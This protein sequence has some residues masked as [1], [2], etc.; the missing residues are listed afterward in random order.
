M[1]TGRRVEKLESALPQADPETAPAVAWLHPVDCRAALRFS[2]DAARAVLDR[3]NIATCSLHFF[4][5]DDPPPAADQVV[6]HSTLGTGHEPKWIEQGTLIEHPVDS[7]PVALG[8]DL[9]AVDDWRLAWILHN[10][11]VARLSPP[12]RELGEEAFAAANDVRQWPPPKITPDLME[13]YFDL[14]LPPDLDAAERLDF[15]PS[16]L[17]TPPGEG[18]RKVLDETKTLMGQA[19]DWHNRTVINFHA[20]GHHEGYSC[21]R[22]SK[23]AL[24]LWLRRR[25]WKQCKGCCNGA[26]PMWQEPA[27]SALPTLLI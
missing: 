7:A 3:Y 17:P 14:P 5:K 19:G 12:T 10:I 1:S 4:L 13:W 27:R 18:W 20:L 11:E 24:W 16:D 15:F 8:L 26:K 23:R 22:K 2:E 21:Y 9:T 25:L 6:L